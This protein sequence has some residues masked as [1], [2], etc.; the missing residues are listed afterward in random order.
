M[1]LNF[2]IPPVQRGL[3]WS[4]SQV[5]ELWDSISKG[6]PIGS[7]TI[8]KDENGKDQLLDGQQRY[9]AIL[10]GTESHADG[11]VWVKEDEEGIPHFMVCTSCHPWGFKEREQ[12]AQL[13]PEEQNEANKTFL[14]EPEPG[15]LDD[16]FIKAPLLKDTHGREKRKELMSPCQRS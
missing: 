1:K 14:G 3:V 5:I 12:N 9:N 11:M 13:S 7:F 15:K 4:P 6:Y 16:L 10:M 2:E 8:Y